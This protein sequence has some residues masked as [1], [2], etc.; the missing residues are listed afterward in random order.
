MEDLRHGTGEV[1]VFIRSVEKYHE[2][3]WEELIPIYIEPSCAYYGVS[4][5]TVQIVAEA[6]NLWGKYR[7]KDMRI[8]L[9]HPV[10]GVLLHELAHHIHY[11]VGGRRDGH[12]HDY[13]F[14]DILN[15][16]FEWW[17]V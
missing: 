14:K 3:V 8:T 17:E 5:P 13:K 12:S 1:G 10:L 9:N 16:L 15:E 4:V 6:K 2:P 7:P 11:E